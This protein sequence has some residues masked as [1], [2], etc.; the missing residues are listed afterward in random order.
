MSQQPSHPQ[1]EVPSGLALYQAQVEANAAARESIAEQ[2]MAQVRALIEAFQSWYD[3]LAVRRLAKQITGIVQSGQKVVA[4]HEDA[5]MSW[6][7]STQ[8]GKTVPPAGQVAVD[9][10]RNGVDPERVY[11]RLAE[12][13][14]YQR[15]VGKT[16]A[17]ALDLVLERAEIVTDTDI[18]LAARAQDQKNLQAAHLAVAYRRV[19][20][21]E[22]SKGGTCGMCI[23]ATDRVYKKGSLL[24]IHDRCHCTVS[25]IMKGGVDPGSSLNNLSLGDLYG[26]ADG[27]QAADLKRTR[28]KVTEHGELGPVL[29]PKRRKKRRT[30]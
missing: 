17:Q 10:L 11:E 9:D 7:L 29:V 13:F 21:P 1:P 16:P 5:Y 30:N 24:P 22:L 25:P 15:S 19:I 2:V 23:A 12:Q 28:Y 3:D 4:A 26:D 14:R 18:T 20:H 8:S 6:V 27:T